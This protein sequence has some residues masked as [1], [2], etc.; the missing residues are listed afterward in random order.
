MS[1][2]TSFKQILRDKM[3]ESASSSGNNTHPNI[4]IDSSNMAYLLGQIRRFEAPV[5]RGNYPAPKVRTQRPQ[6]TF[7]ESQRQSFDFLKSYIC[8][9]SEAFSSGELKKAFRQA[10]ML[11]HPDRGGCARRFMEL[12]QH[13]DNLRC[14]VSL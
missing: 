13:Y 2:Q 4:Y 7:T 12:K 8:D 6:H 9:F 3:G 14:L 1:F 11:L 10:A 5:P